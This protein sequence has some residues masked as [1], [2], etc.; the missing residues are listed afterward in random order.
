[1]DAVYT[2]DNS[3]RSLVKVQTPGFYLSS[4][5]E[6]SWNTSLPYASNNDHHHRFTMTQNI[7]QSLAGYPAFIDQNSLYGEAHM[8]YSDHSQEH[9]TFQEQGHEIVRLFSFISIQRALKQ[10]IGPTAKF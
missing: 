9:V 5:S 4:P 1:M 2:D 10:S 7:H 8:R 3:T 6:D